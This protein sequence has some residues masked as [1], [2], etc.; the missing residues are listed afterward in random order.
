MTFLN[1]IAIYEKTNYNFSR[2]VKSTMKWKRESPGMH[3]LIQKKSIIYLIVSLLLPVMGWYSHAWYQSLNDRK[4][5]RFV[6]AKVKAFRYTSPLL[7]IELPEGYR[8]NREPIPFKYKFKD[9]VKQQITSGQVRN[10]AIYYRDLGDGPWFGINEKVEFSAASMMKVLVMIAWLKRSESEP[11]LLE[12]QLVYDG[13]QDTNLFESI[14]PRESISP[15]RKYRIDE[16]IRYMMMF[17]DNNAMMLLYNGLT[18]EELGDV[19]DGMDINNRP[20]EDSNFISIHSYSGFYRILYNASY[21]N[22]EMSERALH[23][24]S[25]QDFPQ[26][27]VAGVPKGVTVASKFGE[28]AP[29]APGFKQLHECGIVYHPKGPYIV[30]VMTEGDD[31]GR[32]AEIIRTVSAMLYAEVSGAVK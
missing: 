11:K 31:L 26:G 10:M 23:L 27:I 22:R 9:Y 4:A 1:E 16:L 32:Q 8:V 29:V 21:L 13:R 19:M 6:H 20:H 28:Y 24:L 7:D 3:R 2:C 15:G 25:L 30:G 14:K 5:H 18:Q 17:S 12:R